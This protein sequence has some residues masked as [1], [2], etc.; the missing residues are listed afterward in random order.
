MREFLK[1]ITESI[2]EN[3]VRNSWSEG[4][5]RQAEKVQRQG[6]LI[7]IVPMHRATCERNTQIHLETSQHITGRLVAALVAAAPFGIVTVEIRAEGM[8]F[9]SG[10]NGGTNITKAS[11]AW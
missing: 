1:P 4:K 8:C 3:R 5:S 2:D 6:V 7:V 10:S 9:Q 11:S